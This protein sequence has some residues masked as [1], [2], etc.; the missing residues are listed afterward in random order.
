MVYIYNHLQASKQKSRRV[1]GGP[2]AWYPEM[3]AALHAKFRQLRDKGVKIT[4]RWFRLEAENLFKEIYPDT[5]STFKFSDNWF[6]GF[7]KRYRISFRV[8]T[9]KAQ[10]VPADKVDKIRSFHHFIRRNSARG[11]Q[12]GPLGRWAKKDIANM[13]QTPLEFDFN[14]K[15]K[16]YE[17][18]GS[19]TVWCK[20]TGSGRLR[21]L[22]V[23]ISQ[24]DLFSDQMYYINRA[25]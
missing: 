2:K 1:G 17:D 14:L 21:N 5:P 10:N 22:F 24:E 3:E 4:G 16:T 25:R 8:V 6:N 9:N 18:T 13:D 19:K 12:I 7:K 20:S 15:G 11:V 23:I